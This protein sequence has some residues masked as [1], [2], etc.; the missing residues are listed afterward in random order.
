MISRIQNT[1][2]IQDLEILS[3]IK[4]HTIRTWEKRFGL[5]NPTRL[6]RGIRAYSILELQKILNVSLLLKHSYK[7][8]EL[9]KLADVE[10]E[11]K[12]K[13]ISEEKL[14]SNHY[15]N[16]I[17]ISMFSLDEDL[18]EEVYQANIEIDSFELIFIKTYIPLLEHIGALWQTN[19]IQPA[20]EHFISNLI[21]RKILLNIAK[22]PKPIYKSK[23]VNVLFLPEGEMHEI[24]LL[25]M[26]Y[27]L[28][29]SG[30]KVIYLGRNIPID[31]LIDIKSK[32]N[33]INWISSFVINRTNHEKAMFI[34]EMEKLL[35]HTNNTCKIV[36]KVWDE[37]SSNFKHKN[38][39]FFSSFDK[40][41]F[42]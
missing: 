42:D 22:L 39:S 17:I 9:S 15:I 21:Y 28:K 19:G 11:T 8:S 20:N 37:Y 32:F 6:N 24:G 31:D 40:L 16:S 18:F 7:I 38:F 36:G 3:G 27:H 2:N 35:I 10:L 34:A 13:S 5:L 25:Y 33:E 1:F 29:L 14:K 4:A 23:R 41:I 30:E 12:V 26:Q